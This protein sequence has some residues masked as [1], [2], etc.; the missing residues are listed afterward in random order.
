MKPRALAAS[1]MTK[2]ISNRIMAKTYYLPTITG[3]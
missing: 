3:A 1:W 2:L